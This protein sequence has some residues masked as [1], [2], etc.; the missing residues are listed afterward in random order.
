[1]LFT[2]ITIFK[3]DKKYVLDFDM[4]FIRNLTIHGLKLHNIVEIT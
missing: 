3:W 1:M 2:R 4:I